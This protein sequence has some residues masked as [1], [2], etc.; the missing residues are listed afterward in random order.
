[1]IKAVIFDMYETLITHYGCPTY[2]SEEMSKDAG[3]SIEN[4]LPTWRSSEHLRSIGKV[5]FE[6][7]IEKILQDNNVFSDEVLQTI[8]KNRTATKYECFENLH[9]EIIPMLD[10]LKRRGIKIGLISNCF[11]EEAP[12]IR[13]S[14]LSP[15]FDEMFLSWEQGVAKPDVEIFN[16]CI[17]ALDVKSEQ[18]LYIGDG[19]SNEL[20]TAKKVGMKTAQAV[21]YL[22][23]G[24]PYQH[25]R[26]NG[27]VQVETPLEIIKI[28]EEY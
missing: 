2:F 21:W 15:Y 3:I 27:F 16:R 4:F 10:E 26:K 14:I 13:D 28:I 12:V 24:N 25:D 22:Q 23:E 8:C 20:E 19:G 18:C 9:E 6:Q 1:M 7:I 17:K 5:T 11:S